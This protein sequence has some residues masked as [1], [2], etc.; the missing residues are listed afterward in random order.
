MEEISFGEIISYAKIAEDNAKNFYL[1]AAKSAKLA[2]VKEYLESLA[3]EEQTH[4]DYLEALNKKIQAG[5][6]VPSMDKEIHSLGYAEFIKT[7]P[8]DPD[9]SLKD[10]L[11]A[12]MIKEKEAIQTYEK[13]ARF[14]DNAEARKLFNFLA[15][16]ERKHLKRFEDEY[17]DLQDQYY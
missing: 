3:A 16:Q 7:E 8:L 1:D 2:N 15:D 12:A 4:I 17:D 14:I 10:V 6:T 5:G 11:E 13:F 9:A